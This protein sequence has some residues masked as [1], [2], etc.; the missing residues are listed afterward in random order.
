[1]SADAPEAF[2]DARTLLARHGLAA[3]KSFGQNFLVNERAFRAIVD[4]AVTSE[5]DWIVEVGAGLGTLTARLAA[6][7]PDG[8]IIALERDPDMVTVL[9]A[10]LGAI[11]NIH[12][13][14]ADVLRYDLTM[15]A[16]WAAGPITVA[17]NLPY[18]IASQIL[19]RLVDARAHLRR[20]VVMIQKEMADRILDAPGG[21]DYGALG[22]LITT[23]FDARLVTKVGPGS[24]VP[25]PKIDSSVIRLTPLPGAA[26]RVPLADPAHY[27]DVVH[28]AFGQRRKTLRNALRARYPEAAV[29]AA[30][31]T[32]G[33]DGVRRG[34]TLTIA[35]LA[36]VA[37]LLPKAAGPPHDPT[38]RGDG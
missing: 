4:A 36:A 10:E 1:M 34:E 11:D 30:L 29:D 17:G 24:F 20:A 5:D 32:T 23:Y 16:R 38:G 27:A 15:A 18:H 6:R 13:E 25:P 14:P 3:K 28:A 26:P 22:V 33:V 9:R 19:F 37:A 21:K 31:T 7:V 35:E 2:A 12:I 8:K